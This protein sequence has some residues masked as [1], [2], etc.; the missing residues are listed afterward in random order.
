LQQSSCRKAGRK[1]AEKHPG[2]A[3]Y[4][5]G[6]TVKIQTGIIALSSQ[7]SRQKRRQESLLQYKQAGRN[8]CRKM[9]EI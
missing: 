6:I 4:H 5:A 1:T 3:G 7:N 8:D 9:S 2:K